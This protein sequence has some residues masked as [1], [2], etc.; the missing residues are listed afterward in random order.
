MLHD[1]DVEVTMTILRVRQVAVFVR[2][3]DTILMSCP[4]QAAAVEVHLR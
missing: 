1:P 3:G 4:P 2:R